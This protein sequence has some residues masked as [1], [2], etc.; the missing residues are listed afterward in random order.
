MLYYVIWAKDW[1][2]KPISS[3]NWR[4]SICFLGVLVD[5]CFIMRNVWETIEFFF[6]FFL[7]V[8]SKI[9]SFTLNFL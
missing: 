6:P 4:G 2:R 5:T 9:I 8:G 7:G 3:S 1:L